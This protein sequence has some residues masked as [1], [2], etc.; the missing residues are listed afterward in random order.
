MKGDALVAS[1]SAASILAQV[2]RD[3]YLDALALKYPGY[4]FEENAGY[5]TKAHLDGIRRFGMTPEHRQSFHPKSLHVE[6]ELR[7]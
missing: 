5:G 6:M 1:I 3:R 4:A 7:D 2:F